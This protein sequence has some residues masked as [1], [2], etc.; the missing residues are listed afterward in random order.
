V[1]RRTFLQLSGQDVQ[2]HEETISGQRVKTQ[3]GV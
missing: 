3:T 1:K 2:A